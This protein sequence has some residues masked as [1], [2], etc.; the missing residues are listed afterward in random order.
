VPSE[1][2][3]GDTALLYTDGL[4]SVID[5]RGGRM[6]PFELP[7]LLPRKAASAA[8]FL[9]QTIGAAVER[10]AGRPLPDDLAVIVLRRL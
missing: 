5:V 2:Q 9:Q 1:L 8:D 10:A 3:A 4:H 6:T 7:A